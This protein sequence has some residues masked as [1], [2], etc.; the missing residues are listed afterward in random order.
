MVQKSINRVPLGGTSKG[1]GSNTDT[2]PAQS[3]RQLLGETDNSGAWVTKMISCAKAK[4]SKHPFSC[5]VDKR[6]GGHGNLTKWQEQII[7][8]ALLKI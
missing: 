5:C 4:G 1:K 7:T 3:G 6:S 2:S 8:K